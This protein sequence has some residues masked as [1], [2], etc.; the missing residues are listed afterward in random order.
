MLAKLANGPGGDVDL[1]AGP[2][3]GAVGDSTVAG[4]IGSWREP[5]RERGAVVEGGRVDR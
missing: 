4:P 1:W 3:G 2:V 5:C